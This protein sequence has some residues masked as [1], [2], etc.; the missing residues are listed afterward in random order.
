VVA[1]AFCDRG[2][3][4]NGSL[5]ARAGDDG[6]LSDPEA[7]ARRAVTLAVD[8][9]VETVEGT[10]LH[11]VPSTLCLHGD[12]PGAWRLAAAVRRALSAAG[13]RIAPP[14]ER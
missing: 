5:A 10:E 11:L 7:V 6:R 4:A 12:M 9:V 3:L 2:Y 13:V 14:E 1:E 8:G